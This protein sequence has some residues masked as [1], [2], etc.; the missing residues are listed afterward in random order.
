MQKTVL[1]RLITK[2]FLGGAAEAVLWKS[3]GN[4]VEVSCISD[5]KNVLARVRTTDLKIQTGDYGIFDTTQ[6]ASLLG[7]LQDD[8]SFTLKTHK[9]VPIAFTLS[10]ETTKVD[11]VL[12]DSAVIP[13]APGLKK[14]PPY[15]LELT[16]DKK[17]IDTFIRAKSALQDVETFTIL[18]NKKNKPQ[19]IIGYSDMNT[20]R[21]TIDMSTPTD[22]REPTFPLI[23]I[24]FS[25]RFMR[26][27]LMANR[28]AKVGK[29]QV[30]SKGLAHIT[31]E[32][33]SEFAV[34]YYL[35]QIQTASI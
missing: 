19:I 9:D 25:A 7:V 12:S 6:L 27:I 8:V 5:D 30:S 18:C 21:V 1:E 15:D 2:Y 29:I 31:F 3:D 23:P 32:L 24:N 22:T 10:D 4:S 14:L 16:I 34:D 33:D 11:F 26:E 20:N 17:F 28:E 35:V 13:P